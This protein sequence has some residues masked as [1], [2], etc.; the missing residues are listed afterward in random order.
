MTFKLPPV[1]C[2]PFPV[3]GSSYLNILSVPQM[4]AA[5]SLLRGNCYPC[6]HNGCLPTLSRRWLTQFSTHF[7]DFFLNAFSVTMATSTKKTN[8]LKEVWGALRDPSKQGAGKSRDFG[9]SGTDSK[10][11]QTMLG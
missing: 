8:S 5:S 6:T 10:P 1:S 7:F 4:H 9:R 2:V 11:P 3:K